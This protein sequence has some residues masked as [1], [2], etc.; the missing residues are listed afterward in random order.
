[1]Q[2]ART[3]SQM[4]GSKGET[5]LSFEL[6]TPVKKLCGASSTQGSSTLLG[7]ALKL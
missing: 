4:V 5:C 1:M 2:R 6:S 3:G 7:L